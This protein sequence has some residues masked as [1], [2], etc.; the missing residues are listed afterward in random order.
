MGKRGNATAALMR[1]DGKNCHYCGKETVQ[2]NAAP[3]SREGVLTGEA[4][5]RMATKDHIVP[6]SMGGIGNL[7]NF[8]LAC[9]E[10]NEHRSD[11]LHYC[12]CAFCENVISSY[13][14]R[15]FNVDHFGPV[16]PRVWKH[17]DGTWVMSIGLNSY[18]WASWESAMRQVPNT[19]KVN[20]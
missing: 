10:C 17:H 5:L 15:V 16:K 19:R 6:K 13:F 3:H 8:V 12:G 18:G 7:A 9:A 2:S 1:R 4:R 14:Q 11:Q 20:A